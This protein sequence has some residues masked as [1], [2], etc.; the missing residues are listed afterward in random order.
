MG[1]LIGIAEVFNK[2][3]SP[4]EEIDLGNLGYGLFSV[5]SVSIGDVGFYKVGSFPTCFMHGR[6]FNDEQYFGDYNYPNRQVIF[7]RKDTNGNLFIKN[8]HNTSRVFRITRIMKV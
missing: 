7:G 1:E 8:N 6:G 3:I 5:T 2:E 4:N